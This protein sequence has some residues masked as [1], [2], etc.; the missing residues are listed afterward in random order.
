HFFIIPSN[1]FSF[2]IM[3]NNKNTKAVMKKIVVIIPR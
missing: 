3:S 2:S 1:N